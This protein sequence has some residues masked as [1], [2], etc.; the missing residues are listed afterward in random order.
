[1]SESER[2]DFSDSEKSR[3]RGRETA[4]VGTREKPRFFGFGNVSMSSETFSLPHQNRLFLPPPTHRHT[5][6]QTQNLWC[7]MCTFGAFGGDFYVCK[8]G[9][10]GGGKLTFGG[11]LGI[12]HWVYTVVTPSG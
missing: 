4:L 9:K 11:S 8:I 2:R 1:M 7:L 5:A 10:R 3:R 6:H 12:P